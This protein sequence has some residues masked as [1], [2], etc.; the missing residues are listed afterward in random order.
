MDLFLW[1]GPGKVSSA[2]TGR[3]ENNATSK[4]ADII[5]Q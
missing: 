1:L 5:A 4:T 2:W 3:F